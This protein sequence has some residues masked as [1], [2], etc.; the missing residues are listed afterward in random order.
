[1]KR[2]LEIGKKAKVNIKWNVRPVDY[3]DVGANNIRSLF[4]EKYGILRDNVNIEPVFIVKD[5]NNSASSISD[6]M[7]GDIQNPLFQQKLFKEYIEE[8]DIADCDL[9]K[10][11]EI[12]N[13][14]NALIDYE[15]YDKRRRY[16]IK[17]IRWSNFMSY[18]PDNF[19]DFT[20]LDGLCLLTSEPANQG[21]KSTFCID[22]LRFLLFGKVTSRETDWTLSKVFNKYL[23]EATDVTVEGCV[24]IDGSDYVIK[25]VVSRPSLKKRTD[26]SK[27]SQKIY[28]YRLVN[29]E[30]IELEDEDNMEGD[31]GHETNKLIKEAIG[32]EKDFD[33]MICVNDDNLKGLITLKDTDR[34][35]L[36]SRWIGLMPLEEKDRIAREQ[37]NTVISKQLMS[38]RYNKDELT[39]KIKLLTDDNDSYEKVIKEYQ[40]KQKSSE[41]KIEE[42]T[43]RKEN[44]LQSKIKIDELLTT[45]NV[46][47]L[48]NELSVIKENGRN[49][50]AELELNKKKLEELKD[51]KFDENEYNELDS[52]CK[53]LHESVAEL[54]V[55]LNT[56]NDSITALEKG[57]FCPTCGARLKNVDNTD[58]IKAKKEERDNII[59]EGKKIRKESDDADNKKVEL[60]KIREKYNEKIRLEL[61]IEKNVVDIE[62]LRNLYKEKNTILKNVQAN[63]EAIKT[64]GDI[65]AKI[66]VEN[67]T[68][69]V[70]NQLLND[71]KEQIA[72]NKAQITVNKKSIEDFNK[73][74]EVLI[75]EEAIIKNWKV[76]LDMV[77][78]NGISKMVLRKVLPFINGEL[79]RVLSG[80]CDFTVEVSID[81]HND[82]AFSIIH[83]GVSSSLGSGSGFEKTAAS[84]ALRSVLSKISSFSKPSFVVFDE[85]LGGVADENYENIKLLYDKIAKDYAFVLQISHLKNIYEW[86]THFIKIKKNNDISSIEIV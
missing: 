70:E 73:I 19:F 5:D 50:G 22:L 60:A 51:I 16:S 18:G 43:K 39:D 74:I 76:Y 35:R 27:V 41:K 52:R 48:E 11:I 58:K 9:N 31:T 78:K 64:N 72:A 23:P 3:S 86:H 42:I 17:W 26:K 34:G 61:L 29:D 44:L 66:N 13:S 7:I 38:N 28:Y 2:K 30:Y 32:S 57:E 55:R 69:K 46:T 12:D 67:E 25:R 84:L 47:S 54:R 83:N 53:T 8:K 10:I 49:K 82:V 79:K 37:Y 20:K 24:E 62:N 21:G 85:I 1:M 15:V 71:I 14:I 56:C 45:A 75:K 63:K 40:K 6:T 80:V 36:V 4:A 59:N 33:L 65:D 81:N 68:L 77:G